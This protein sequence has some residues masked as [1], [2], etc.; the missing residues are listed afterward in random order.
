MVLLNVSLVK[1]DIVYLKTTVPTRIK[2]SDENNLEIYL[3][4]TRINDGS[5]QASKERKHMLSSFVIFRLH[6]NNVLKRVTFP[7][8][9]IG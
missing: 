4:G 1:S 3:R 9:L 5:L 6:T 7:G 8:F 2:R